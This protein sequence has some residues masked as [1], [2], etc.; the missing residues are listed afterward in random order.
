MTYYTNNLLF[1]NNLIY[2]AW[3]G[4]F[5]KGGTN[6][7]ITI[8][9]NVIRDCAKALR[10]SFTTNLRFYQNIIHD[11]RSAFQPAEGLVNANFVNNVVHGDLNGVANWFASNNFSV[12]NN[13]FFN[14]ASPFFFEGG[15]GTPMASNRNLFFGYTHFQAGSSRVNLAGWVATFGFDGASIEADPLL[16]NPSVR[17]YR[18]QSASPARNAGTDILDLNGDGNFAEAINLGPYITGLEIIGPQTSAPP[19]QANL[20]P[21]RPQG[22]RLQ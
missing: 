16:L 9:F 17:D 10:A 22:L 1:E 11:C 5:P 18:L 4:F 12:H 14:N 7:N 6:T 3:S 19:V 20:A 15:L 8:R 13:I 2:D 21:A